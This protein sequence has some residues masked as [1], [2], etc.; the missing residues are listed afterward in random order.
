MGARSVSLLNTI[1]GVLNSASMRSKPRKAWK[2]KSIISIV[3]DG[4]PAD[5]WSSIHTVPSEA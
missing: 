3:V 4:T 5:V 1:H 2:G